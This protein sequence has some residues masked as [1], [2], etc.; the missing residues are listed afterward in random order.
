MVKEYGMSKVGQV[1]YASQRRAQFL[2]PLP[3]SPG[4]YSEATAERI[5]QEV[6]GIISA[7]YGRALEILKGRR[8]LL[9]ASVT[10]LLEKETI[11]G[12]ELKQLID[13]VSGDGAAALPGPA[14]AA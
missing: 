1:Y 3:E 4:E 13:K 8:E 10:V 14:A 9:E 5:D 12:E 6:Q 11:E 2:N 7:Q